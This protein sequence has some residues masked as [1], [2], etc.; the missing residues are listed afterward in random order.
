[1]TKAKELFP[2]TFDFELL[3][4]YFIILNFRVQ[5]AEHP[6]AHKI[7]NVSCKLVDVS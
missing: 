4:F 5:R 3:Q 2:L 6:R 7:V 1:M